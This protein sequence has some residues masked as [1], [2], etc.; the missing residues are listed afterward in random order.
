MLHLQASFCPAIKPCSSYKTVFKDQWKARLPQTMCELS[1]CNTHAFAHLMRLLWGRG[2]QSGGPWV[3]LVARRLLLLPL[4]PS[5]VLRLP[6]LVLGRSG[7][8][9]LPRSG[10]HNRDRLQLLLGWTRGLQGHGLLGRLGHTVLPREGLAHVLLSVSRSLVG[11]PGRSFLLLAARMQRAG[12][13]WRGQTDWGWHLPLRRCLLLRWLL[14]WRIPL[15]L[16]LQRLLLRLQLGGL[17]N[18][19]L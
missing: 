8:P 16:L 4:R 15:W 9:L 7:Q 5:L 18:W 2:L 17:L 11:L 10:K 14:R 19:E 13:S 3:L 1:T 12:A 6:R